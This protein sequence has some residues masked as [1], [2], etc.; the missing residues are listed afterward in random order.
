MKKKII[1]FVFIL[2]FISIS[3][4]LNYNF[5]NT[6]MNNISPKRSNLF[7]ISSSNWSNATVISDDSTLWNNDSSSYPSIAVD[8]TGNVHVVW[9]D[10]TH[11]EWGTDSEIM[12]ANHTIAGWSNATV[13]SDDG[14]LWND[15][16]SS[17]PSI[18]VDG[19]GNVHVVWQDY[20]DGEW[21]TDS[22]IMYANC[23]AAGWSNATVISDNSTLWNNGSSYN[24]SVAVDGTGNVHVVWSDY[25]NG[26]WGTD[27]EIMYVNRTAAGWSNATVISDDST[28]WNNGGSVY[29]SIAVD[30]TGN[31]H[32][33]WSDYTNGTWGTDSEIMYA[34]RTAAGWSNAT[35]IS[36]DGTLWNDDSSSYPSIAVDSTGNVHVVW[37]DYTDGEW[38]TDSEIMYANRTAA[39]WSNATV[40]SDDSTLWNNGHSWKPSIAVDSDG[41]VYVVWEDDTKFGGDFD[42]M[43]TNRT[44]AGWSKAIV[45]SDDGTFWNDG[46]SN[47]PSIAV[48]GTGNVH[49]VWRDSTDGEWG[50]DSEIMYAKWS[51]NAQQENPL[52]ILILGIQRPAN[53]GLLIIIGIGIASTI[54]IIIVVIRK[55]R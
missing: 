28:L 34:N 23:T 47:Y 3:T 25:T 7:C 11:G 6:A 33:V 20:T 36:D 4:L 32:V 16:S 44:A 8:G 10:Y 15:D 13:I 26:T 49:V 27:S 46:G 38:G 14:T 24:P 31:V 1:F 18:A 22:E 2:Q 35:V 19:T 30:S 21:G 37:Q 9:H 40:I 41:N 55:R 42:I 53:S 51:P 39:G 45:L 17:Y 29:P 52:W 50:T 12:Y 48:Y 54:V 43:Y 5:L